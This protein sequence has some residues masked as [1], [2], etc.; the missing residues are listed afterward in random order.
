MR[1]MPRPLAHSPVSK[2]NGQRIDA[3]FDFVER[4]LYGVFEAGNFDI[5]V[6][7][8]EIITSV[9]SLLLPAYPIAPLSSFTIWKT[10]AA[11]SEN[12]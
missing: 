8:G 9:E 3:V 6:F 11:V 2:V 1:M 7:Q 12:F 10:R 4:T 5:D